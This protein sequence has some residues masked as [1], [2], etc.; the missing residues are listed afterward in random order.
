MT[1]I[2]EVTPPYPYPHREALNYNPT[3]AFLKELTSDQNAWS[4]FLSMAVKKLTLRDAENELLTSCSTNLCALL[5]IFNGEERAV[6]YLK[7]LNFSTCYSISY[8]DQKIYIHNIGSE[9]AILEVNEEYRK[10]P[11]F[12]FSADYAIKT[13][14]IKECWDNFTK[15]IQYGKRE[16]TEDILEV[17]RT[18][19][20]ALSNEIQGNEKL[21]NGTESF[22]YQV[23]IRAP[24]IDFQSVLNEED[25]FHKPLL[26]CYHSF[27]IEQYSCSSSEIRYFLYHTWVGK[28]S[29][30]DH[31]KSKSCD[32]SGSMSK[33]EL[34]QFF[35]FLME[36]LVQHKTKG[37]T[38][39][40]QKAELNCFGVN[41]K[42]VS[43]AIAFNKIVNA[44]S[45]K[46]LRYMTTKITPATCRMNYNR[47]N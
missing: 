38:R 31:L 18:I 24:T 37:D 25:L 29:L 34:D 2:T 22:V 36:L 14:K 11:N 40:L 30:A 32:G 43:S 27:V 26:A 45:G 16:G 28:F 33:H 6:E 23:V 41:N 39:L 17:N 9:H 19:I 7:A 1:T 35:G 8:F 42:S 46:S 47:F 12:H 21:I 3:V 44:F 13:N 15:E 5:I 20:D 4:N 10:N